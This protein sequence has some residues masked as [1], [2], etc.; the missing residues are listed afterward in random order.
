MNTP[1]KY[2]RRKNAYVAKMNTPLTIYNMQGLSLTDAALTAEQLDELVQGIDAQPWTAVHGWQRR[3]VQ[4]YGYAYDYG[5][6]CVTPTTP[7]PPFL[8]AA[9]EVLRTQLPG[10]E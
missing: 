8:D 6:R 3:R 1:Q 2:I 4:H 9:L 10:V 5:R 7:F